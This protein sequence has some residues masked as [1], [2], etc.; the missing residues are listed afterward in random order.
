M[1]V[2][3]ASQYSSARPSTEV[4]DGWSAPGDI[5][6]RDQIH[7][8][9][10]EI[11]GLSRARDSSDTG[12]FNPVGISG[13]NTWDLAKYQS[14]N[15]SLRLYVSDTMS[16]GMEPRHKRPRLD[17]QITGGEAVLVT[18]STPTTIVPMAMTSLPQHEAPGEE[19]RHDPS[20]TMPV[21]EWDFVEGY[22]ADFWSFIFESGAPPATF[23][24][25]IGFQPAVT[26]QAVGDDN[27]SFPTF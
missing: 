6:P 3:N 25:D 17:E 27:P 7:F 5:F 12:G 16:H 9:S 10:G 24:G 26:D 1:T 21:N 20:M 22:S 4:G 2:P 13:T 23:T 18:T 11:S 8:E 14:D 19:T 15:N